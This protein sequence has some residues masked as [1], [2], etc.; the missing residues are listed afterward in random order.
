MVVTLLTTAGQRLLELP[1]SPGTH[2]IGS[3]DTASLRIQLP[4]IEPLHA[5]LSVDD[6]GLTVE[7]LVDDKPVEL[8]QIP[9][10]STA[11]MFPGQRLKLGDLF[12]ELEAP[13]P[14][15]RPPSSDK[16]AIGDVFARGG[17]GVVRSALDPEIGR[18]VAVKVLH[19]N[20]KDPTQKHRFLNEARLTAR[21]QHP[22]IVP[23]YEL[24][25]EHD[26]DNFYVMKLV[27]GVTL[28]K[29]LDSLAKDDAEMAAKYPLPTLLTAFGKVCDAIAYAHSRNVVHRDLKPD[30]IMLGN[31]GEVFVMDWG[32]AREFGHNDQS[33]VSLSDASDAGLTLDGEVVGTPQYMSPEQARAEGWAIDGRS[34]IYALGGILYEI[35]ALRASISMR[36]D[37][38]GNEGLLDILDRVGRGQITLISPPKNIR[39]QHLPSGR[40]PEAFTAIVSKAMA[41]DQRA[42]YKNVTALQQDLERVQGG[43]L[44]TAENQTL[45][46]K[47]SLF[48]ARNRTLLVASLLLLFI[49]STAIFQTIRSGQNAARA[50]A[51]LTSTASSLLA[52]A[53]REASYNHLDSALEKLDA[54]HLLNPALRIDPSL[55]VWIHIAQGQ[56][57]PAANALRSTAQGD[58]AHP[59]AAS[60]LPILSR[61]FNTP[62]HDWS[63]EDRLALLNTLETHGRSGERLHLTHLLQASAAPILSLIQNQLASRPGGDNFIVSI[64]S[65]GLIA[66]ELKQFSSHSSLEP[67]RALPIRSL[68]LNGST[69]ISD[70]SHIAGLKLVALKISGSP[71]TDLGPLRGMPIE[72]LEAH[73]CPLSSIDILSGMRLRRLTLSNKA[74]KSANLSVLADAPLEELEL[75]GLP[76]GD[77]TPLSRK[78]LR[79]LKLINSDVRDLAPLHGAPIRILDLQGC[80]QLQSANQLAVLVRLRELTELS[81]PPNAELPELLRIHP[82][83]QKVRMIPFAPTYQSKD[84]FWEQYQKRRSQAPAHPRINAAWIWGDSAAN[85]KFP[86]GN[87]QVLLR[88]T[89]KLDAPPS[90]GIALV[91][92]DDV[93]TLYINDKPVAYSAELAKLTSIPL[94]DKLQK[95]DNHIV[96]AASNVGAGS[97]PAGFFF[98]AEAALSNGSRT[99]LASNSS[100]ECIPRSLDI[101]PERY[102]ELP[103]DWKPATEVTAN[104]QWSAIIS[105][106]GPPLLDQPAAQA[107][108]R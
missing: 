26:G 30:N 35:L 8:D 88:T 94:H 79:I 65:R 13:D 104:A 5:R 42:R 48:V 39:F 72:I 17:M 20:L 29:I 59:S 28:K 24:V 82:A 32:V 99:S 46:R 67:L 16:Y 91:T 78:P 107:P 54:A 25:E 36:P 60:L 85:G 75:S 68:N 10:E 92:C 95:G 93:F 96:V 37:L 71:V 55:R 45:R 23:V 21:L 74:L 89:W 44:T 22:S 43:Y 90:S 7:S 86:P 80:S 58:T 98:Y 87:E 100:W 12:L 41:H 6:F 106:Q 52:A 15:S 66:V 49:A 83:L 69:T 1:L 9:L 108:A 47:L 64:D 102:A 50:L 40:I 57:I 62:I 53:D 4:G 27:Q 84:T 31:Y 76:V 38:R 3:A 73:G 63:P 11:L 18:T 61:L 34:D 103:K 51:E 70:L 33:E 97:N 101:R 81:L 56:P 19:S 77:L 105:S 2:T 14:S